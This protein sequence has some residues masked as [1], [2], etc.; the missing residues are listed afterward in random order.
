MCAKAWRR[1]GRDAHVHLRAQPHPP[2]PAPPHLSMTL[3]SRWRSWSSSVGCISSGRMAL[4]SGP[5]P[6]SRA[7]SVSVLRG[8]RG[9]GGSEDRGKRA[10]CV[11]HW[12]DGA[13]VGSGCGA[14]DIT[15]M[16]LTYGTSQHEV[17]PGSRRNLWCPGYCHTLDV[18]PSLAAYRSA[19][20]L[21]GGVPFLTLSSSFMILRSLASSTD[22]SASSTSWRGEEGRKG[23]A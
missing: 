19:L 6:K 7:L 5:A 18:C 17:V 16:C 8:D 21:C 9:I 4:N 22:S 2:L 15:A 13:V 1:G 12:H 11:G 10:P 20:F 14:T 23:C 3:T